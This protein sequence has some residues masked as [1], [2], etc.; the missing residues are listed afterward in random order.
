M[1]IGASLVTLIPRILPLVVLSRM[2]LPDWV[3]RWLHHIPIAVMSALLAQALLVSNGAFSPSPTGLLA[4]L[5]AF[6]AAYLTRSLLASVVTG[7]VAM[8]LLRYVWSTL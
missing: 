4:A 2:R 1:L 8:M 5:P 3:L 7:I 6:V